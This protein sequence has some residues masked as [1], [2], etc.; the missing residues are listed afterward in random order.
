[1]NRASQTIVSLS[2]LDGNL[3]IHR[4]HLQ[5]SLWSFARK[6]RGHF[7]RSISFSFTLKMSCP[8]SPLEKAEL[9]ASDCKTESRMK[10]FFGGVGEEAL[11]PSLPPGGRGTAL[12]VEGACDNSDLA[13]LN[14]FIT[15]S[16]SPS[17]VGSSLPE[18]AF[19]FASDNKTERQNKSSVFGGSKPPPYEV[20]P[21]QHSHPN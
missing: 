7:Q 19:V 15:H 9:R 11:K 18:G 13:M 20:R 2:I 16:P 4:F 17:F 8:P 14:F 10:P 3:L 1:M 12:A 5:A 21:S 6:A